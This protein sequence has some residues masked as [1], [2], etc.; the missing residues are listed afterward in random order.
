LLLQMLVNG[1]P[2]RT[3]ADISR[4]RHIKSIVIGE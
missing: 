1:R 4:R 3:A 2:D